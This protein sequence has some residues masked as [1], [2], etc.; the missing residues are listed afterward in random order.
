VYRIKKAF[1]MCEKKED[2]PG[3]KEREK[4]RNGEKPLTPGRGICLLHTLS[5]C[6][7]K[8]LSIERRRAKRK[9][10][11]GRVIF[12]NPGRVSPCAGED[13]WGSCDHPRVRSACLGDGKLKEREGQRRTHSLNKNTGRDNNVKKKKGSPGR[14]IRTGGLTGQKVLGKKDR[15]GG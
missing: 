12:V 6:G 3:K 13:V 5:R 1:G 8:S 4:A 9:R 11:Q 2:A 14:V 7:K 15:R 10:G